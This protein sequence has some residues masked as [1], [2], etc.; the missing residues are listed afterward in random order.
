MSKRGILSVHKQISAATGIAQDM[1]ETPAT[2]VSKHKVPLTAEEKTLREDIRTLREKV[3][4]AHA[5]T[6][7]N[8]DKRIMCKTI[9]RVHFSSYTDGLDLGIERR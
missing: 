9:L 8:D 6:N 1:D 7:A 4:S 2:E 5:A 3:T